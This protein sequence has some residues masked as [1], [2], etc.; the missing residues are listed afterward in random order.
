MVADSTLST[1]R[2]IEPMALIAHLLGR[3]VEVQLANGDLLLGELV[4]ADSQ[5][6]VLQPDGM[7]PRLVT[8]QHIVWLRP[9]V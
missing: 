3:Q 1:V 4:G 7:E 5:T 6:I 9:A 8:R 2:K